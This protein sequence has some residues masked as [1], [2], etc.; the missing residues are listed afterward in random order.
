MRLRREGRIKG[1][2]ER[3]AAYGGRRG[4]EEHGIVTAWQRCSISTRVGV[5]RWSRVQKGYS[6]GRNVLGI[7]GLFTA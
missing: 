3:A 6:Q 4:G 1:E 7:L 2:G 5:E